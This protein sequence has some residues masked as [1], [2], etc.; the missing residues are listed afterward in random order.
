MNAS[1]GTAYVAV[2][3]L[4]VALS[5]PASAAGIAPRAHALPHSSPAQPSQAR[6][7]IEGV[8]PTLENRLFDAT[9]R[10]LAS[11]NVLKVYVF[12]G[13]GYQS[14]GI[15]FSARIPHEQGDL[16]ADE[17]A[18]EAVSLIHTTF[19]AFPQ[20][21]TLDVWATIPVPTSELAE[22][23]STVFSVSADRKTYESIRTQQLDDVAFL[24][25]FG[26]VWISPEVSQ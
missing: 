5:A 22:E 26:Q 24:N 2:A 12:D 3:L 23:E 11:H 18:H 16:T 17:L 4:I 1:K 9:Y 7:W 20:I 10:A 8:T 15:R 21:Q 13:A 6:P 25:A 14:A 19:D